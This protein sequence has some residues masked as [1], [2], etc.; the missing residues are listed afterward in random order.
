MDINHKDGYG[1]KIPKG[2]ATTLL[3]LV[4]R[5]IQDNI[6]FPLNSNITQFTRDDTLRTIPMSS[7]MREFTFRGPATFGQTFTFELADINCGDLI[8]GMYIQLQLSDWLTELTRNKLINGTF[9]PSTPSQLWTYCNSIGTSILQEASLEVDDQVLERITGDSV[10]VT[11]LLF[12]DLNTQV[13]LSDVLGIKSINYIK[14]ATGIR[15]F[16][17]E[18]GWIT[19]P[20]VFSMLREKLTATFPLIS[21]RA[22]TI[23]IR[24][25]LKKFSEVVRIL[26]GSRVS[27]DDTPIGKVFQFI[28][29]TKT[30]NKL[31]NITAYTDE[32]Q[33]KNIQLLTQGVFVDGPYREML[34]RQPFERPFRE[35]QQFD[36]TEPLK[37]VVNKSGNDL[38]TV[39]LPLEANGPVEEIVWFLRRKA[40]V[41]LNN[42]WTNYSATLEKD[43][44]PIFAPLEPLLLSARIQAN[45]Q[46]I[47]QKDEAWFRSQIA[48]AHKSGKTSYDAFVYGY[49]FAKHPGQHDP[50]GTINA[51]RLNSLRLTLD[52]KPPGGSSD[53]EWEVHVFVYAFQWVRFGNGICNKVFID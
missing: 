18:D 21:C 12:P 33:L 4:S 5:D 3:D 29:N 20:L 43:Y 15:H 49:S 13:G 53:T 28:D 22:G 37:Y 23:R 35:I 9:V 25:T 8:S 44:H 30:I 41:T 17:T 39:Q 7:V 27:C 19:V 47:I 46:D 24:I 50:T 32:P 2:S 38:I 11:S 31:T 10:H 34:L 16:F 1:T 45:G 51:S 42:D 52:V 26:S 40:A 14:Q 48:R 6:L 36:F